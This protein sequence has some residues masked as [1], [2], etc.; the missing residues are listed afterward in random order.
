MNSSRCIEA[1]GTFELEPW[2]GSADKGGGCER[3]DH[4]NGCRSRMRRSTEGGME[5]GYSGIVIGASLEV[6]V[7]AMRSNELRELV[8]V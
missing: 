5:A 1:Y 7:I 3:R 6:V 4:D 2:P 8:P